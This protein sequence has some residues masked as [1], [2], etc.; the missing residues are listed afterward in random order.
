[1]SSGV[2]A[3][4]TKPATTA[5]QH[6]DGRARAVLSEEMINANTI[7]L[8]RLEAHGRVGVF[9]TCSTPTSSGCSSDH[10]PRQ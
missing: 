6:G 2:A 4:W 1:M 10:A 8:R 5:L 7:I 3:C 9:R